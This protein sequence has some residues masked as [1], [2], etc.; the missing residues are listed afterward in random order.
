MFQSVAQIKG[1]S[2]GATV[3]GCG[4]TGMVHGTDTL[5]LLVIVT[6]A[7]VLPADKIIQCIEKNLDRFMNISDCSSVKVVKV[8]RLDSECSTSN[9]D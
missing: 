5:D 7:I 8:P 9:T 1:M 6:N 2:G 3:N 4:Y